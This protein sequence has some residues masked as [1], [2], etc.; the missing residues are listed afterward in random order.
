MVSQPVNS[1]SILSSNQQK[2]TQHPCKRPILIMAG[3][4]PGKTEMSFE[5]DAEKTYFKTK[6]SGL[7]RDLSQYAN[8]E[9]PQM[10]QGRTILLF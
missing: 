4:E 3:K 2:S 5:E 8:V 10:F 9:P 1:Y 7:F 6:L